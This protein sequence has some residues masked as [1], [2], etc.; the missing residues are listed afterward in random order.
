MEIIQTE[1][2]RTRTRIVP[3]PAS[4]FKSVSMP[5]I[6]LSMSSWL[7][8]SRS[9]RPYS[10]HSRCLAG[11][12]FFRTLHPASGSYSSSSSVRIGVVGRSSHS[13]VAEAPPDIA[14][15]ER[16]SK[17]ESMCMLI[18]TYAFSSF[19]DFLI[20]LCVV[21]CPQIDWRAVF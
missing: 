5:H 4:R 3:S 8:S 16:N 20:I 15:F 19:K 14:L 12:L 17:A 10:I 9:Q 2:H 7:H 13:R 21:F 11:A 18:P 1:N 6:F